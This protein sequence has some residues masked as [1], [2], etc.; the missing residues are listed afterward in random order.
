LAATRPGGGGWDPEEDASPRPAPSPVA[1]GAG[2]PAGRQRV[3][4]RAAVRRPVA[5]WRVIEGQVTGLQMRSEGGG[6]EF[7]AEAIWTFRLERYDGAG[8]RVALVPVEMRGLRFE[9]SL[10]NGDTV[11]VRGRLRRGTFLASEV[12][13]F[14]TGSEVRAKGVPKVALVF[15][16]I[17]FVAVVAFIGWIAYTGFT[18]DSGPPDDFEMPAGP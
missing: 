15:V 7:A 17:F 11:R 14:T 2:F 16:G 8:N 10:A 1:A 3:G 12:V 18:T 13:N 5:G 9:G 4:V 6:G